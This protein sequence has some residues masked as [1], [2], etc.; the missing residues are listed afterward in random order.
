MNVWL[1]VC[2]TC[3]VKYIAAAIRIDHPRLV[4]APDPGVATPRRYHGI[5]SWF[6][7]LE[8][9]S[10][11]GGNQ[12]KSKAKT[13]HLPGPARACPAFATRKTGEISGTSGHETVVYNQCQSDKAQFIEIIDI[14]RTAS[15]P[16]WGP[17]TA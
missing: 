16:E 13:R 11:A 12:S 4:P 5:A 9:R 1:C 14:F 8:R 6:L 10:G 15:G 17:I 3:D 7:G 2:R